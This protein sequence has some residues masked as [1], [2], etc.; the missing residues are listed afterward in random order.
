MSAVCVLTLIIIGSWPIIA[1]A[2]TGVAAAMGFS[3]ASSAEQAESRRKTSQQNQVVL[4]VPNSEIVA[5]SIEDDESLV[6]VR[7]DVRIVFR[8]NANGTCSACISGQ[9]RSKAE[10]ESIGQEVTGRVVQQYAYNKLITELKRRNYSVVD[11]HV[12]ED[13]S[14][15]VRVRLNR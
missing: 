8:R 4:E 13:E 2:V 5:E 6:L 9:G 1:S 10:L 3:I 15:H 14:I 11:E 12:Q 7:E